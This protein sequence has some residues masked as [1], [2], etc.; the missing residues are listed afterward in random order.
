MNDIKTLQI[1]KESTSISMHCSKNTKKHCCKKEK[2]N[3]SCCEHKTSLFSCCCTGIHLFRLEENDAT[4]NT[5]DLISFRKSMIF[6]KHAL[7]SFQYL[8][9]IDEPPQV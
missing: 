8:Y 4:F 3:R 9:I 7:Y 5:L 6:S 1:E 2:E